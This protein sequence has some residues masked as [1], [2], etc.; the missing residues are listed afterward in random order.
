M[1]PEI[2]TQLSKAQA[3][4]ERAESRAIPR[5][6]ELAEATSDFQYISKIRNKKNVS[7]LLFLR[8][9]KEY[10]SALKEY[11]KAKTNLVSAGDNFREAKALRDSNFSRMQKAEAIA[12]QTETELR[13]TKVY[14]PANGHVVFDKTN[15]AHRLSAGEPFLKLVGDDPWIVANFNEYQAKRIK[16]N[17]KA[18]IRIEAIKERTFEGK[19][20]NVGSVKHGGADLPV[21]LL[22]LFALVEPPQT[23]PV[24]I[25]FDSES[26]IGFAER[27]DPDLNSFVEIDTG[28]RQD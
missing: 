11:D 28:T 1:L 13:F 7:P 23:V 19:V 9:K 12:R 15:L 10:E 18:R 20:V 4:F 2:E 26:V 17:Q 21:T 25:E 16:L 8:G 5:E 22:S 14:A 6:K 3:E 27:I 24:K